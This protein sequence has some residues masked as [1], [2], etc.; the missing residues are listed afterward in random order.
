MA[1][2]SEYFVSVVIGLPKQKILYIHLVRKTD[3]RIILI[4][5]FDFDTF[6]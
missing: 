1:G 4:N 6:E 5:V 3:S 2:V